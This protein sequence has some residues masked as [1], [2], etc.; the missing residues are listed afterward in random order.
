MTSHGYTGENIVS[1]KRPSQ[2]TPEA[3][4]SVS[5]FRELALVG[6]SDCKC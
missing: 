4:L 3:I 1:D 6:L 5:L 2:G